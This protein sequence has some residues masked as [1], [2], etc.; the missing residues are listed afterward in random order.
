MQPL[1]DE[2]FR[3]IAVD[4]RGAG[5]SSHPPSG[6][7][8]KTM[9]QDVYTLYHDK[10]GIDKAVVVDFGQSVS[11]SFLALRHDTLRLYSSTRSTDKA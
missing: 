4:Y 8:K 6:Y 1:A 7:D 9:A 3:V 10:L 2:G 5:D 11:C